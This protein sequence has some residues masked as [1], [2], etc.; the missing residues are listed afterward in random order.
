MPFANNDGV[1]LYYETTGSGETVVFVGEAGYGAWLWSWQ[2]PAIAGPYEALVPVMRGTGRSDRPTGPYSVSDLAGDLEAVLAAHGARRVHLVGAGLGG[3]VALEVALLTDRTASLVLFG[4]AATSTD[5]PT[6]PLAAMRAPLTDREALATSLEPVLSAAFRRAN[7]DV[8]EGIA[9][10]RA[11]DDA[12]PQ[13]AAWQAAAVTSFDRTDRLTEVR[14]PTLVVHGGADDVVPVA[15]GRELAE[16]LP[17]GDFE[18]FEGAGHLVFVE[19]SRPVNDV[20]LGH[21]ETHRRP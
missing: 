6:A 4:T 12:D 1:S 10:W 17:R 11:R 3:M 20:V 21:L 16:G 2:H 13:A 14:V 7:P 18:A 8:V 5:L 9:A 15:S 19:R